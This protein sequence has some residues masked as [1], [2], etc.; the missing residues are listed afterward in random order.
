MSK[1]K[2]RFSRMFLSNFLFRSSNRENKYI[3]DSA[4]LN[5]VSGKCISINARKTNMSRTFFIRKCFTIR[6]YIGIQYFDIDFYCLF[7]KCSFASLKMKYEH[8]K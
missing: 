2:D 1:H 4:T 6:F 7:S 8:D 3:F 5:R